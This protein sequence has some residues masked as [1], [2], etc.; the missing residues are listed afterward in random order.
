MKWFTKS[1]YSK[2]TSIKELEKKLQEDYKKWLIETLTD[3][4]NLWIKE[5]NKTLWKI[6]KVSSEKKKYQIT[7]ELEK[8]ENNLP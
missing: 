3:Y 8:R 1:R 4:L 7:K 6:L 5:L 2:M